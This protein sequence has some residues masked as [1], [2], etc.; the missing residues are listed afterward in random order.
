MNVPGMGAGFGC[1]RSAVGAGSR[2]KIRCRQVEVVRFCYRAPLLGPVLRLHRLYFTI[3]VWR[4][5]VE[6]VTIPSRVD[7]KI[8]PSPAPKNIRVRPA[9]MGND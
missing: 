4:V 3:F 8:S 6:D 5:F 9:L 2:S 7:A 1:G